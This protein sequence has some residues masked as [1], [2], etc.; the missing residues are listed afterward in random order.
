MKKAVIML[1][2]VILFV[3]A[4]VVS[5]PLDK[6]FGDGETRAA[7]RTDKL[8]A[9]LRQQARVINSELPITIGDDAM[10]KSVEAEIDIEAEDCKALEHG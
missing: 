1:T 10:M 3:A 8:E 6:L 2:I 5:A 9:S 7:K 4:L